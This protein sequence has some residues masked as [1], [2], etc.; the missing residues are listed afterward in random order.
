MKS[1]RPRSI[2]VRMRTVAVVASM[3]E[4][5]LSVECTWVRYPSSDLPTKSSRKRIPFSAGTLVSVAVTSASS[6]FA[7]IFTNGI[8]LVR[9]LSSRAQ[10]TPVLGR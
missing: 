9:L 5:I 8:L 4:G 10:S 3:L 1:S 6:A 2:L 7:A